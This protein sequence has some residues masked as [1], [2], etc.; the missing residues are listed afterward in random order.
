EGR[1]EEGG[2]WGGGAKKPRPGPRPPAVFK[3]K[4]GPPARRSRPPRTNTAH[5]YPQAA[6][7]EVSGR[8]WP[9]SGRTS[10]CSRPPPLNLV[11]GLKAPQRRGLLNSVVRLLALSSSQGEISIPRLPFP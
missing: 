2:A 8:R 5:R 11:R 9:K 3:G 1:R 6:D 10:R 4:P 7:G